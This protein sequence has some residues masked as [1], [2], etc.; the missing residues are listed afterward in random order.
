MNYQQLTQSLKQGTLAPVYLL[1]G[2]ENYLIENTLKSI[3]RQ[4]LKSGFTD[5]NHQVFYG[6]DALIPDITNAALTAP[7]MADK[8]LVVVKNI[9]RIK[10]AQLNKLKDYIDKP[11]SVSVLVLIGDKLDSKKAWVKS[12]SAKCTAVR[13]YPLYDRQ[14]VSFILTQAKEQGYQISPGAAQTL[15]E[16][17]GNNLAGLANQLEKLY[18]YT[19]SEKKISLDDVEQVVGRVKQ[20]NIFELVE[21]MSNKKLE[22]ALHILAKIMAQGEPP[23]LILALIG[24][25]L[26]RIWK[27]K[28]MRAQG[29]SWEKIGPKL[30]I[31][32]FFLKNF[33]SQ[34]GYFNSSDLKRAFHNLL[35]TDMRLKSGALL[36]RLS[37]EMLLL[38]LC[39]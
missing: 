1:Y 19:A 7:M 32:K 15:L 34:V 29:D 23:Q 26:R 31:P 8:R 18:A 37:L 13:F 12:I 3:E 17:S 16:L 27:A 4:T 30:G 38:D 33:I 2:E 35:T 36:P 9:E 5:F 25:Q 28:Y 21:A 22:Q 24:R 11:S 39:R 6:E 20:H 14:A 10:T